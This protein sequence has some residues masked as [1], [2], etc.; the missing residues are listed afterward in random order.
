MVWQSSGT[1][2]SPGAGTV[3]TEDADAVRGGRMKWL[4]CVVAVSVSLHASAE[5]QC[6]L[7]ENA[8]PAIPLTT[9]SH[10][11]AAA[12]VAK[13]LGAQRAD[14]SDATLL[15][16]AFVYV[17]ACPTCGTGASSHWDITGGLQ[18]LLEDRCV[19]GRVTQRYR[20]SPD[21]SRVA[22]VEDIL[23]AIQTGHPVVAT[24]S[25]SRSAAIPGVAS[26]RANNCFSGVIIGATRIDDSWALIARDGVIG[27]EDSEAQRF[28]LVTLVEQSEAAE[29]LAEPGTHLYAWEMRNT[30]VVLTMVNGDHAEEP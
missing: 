18:A 4:L 11:T 30:N 8:P 27:T 3:P 14:E 9:N 5:P 7:L 26:Q 16:T 17:S 2:R 20:L 10:V 12:W 13:Y 22:S 15:A 1:R 29:L 23:G 21:P 19:N 24:F 25:S 28:R 6:V